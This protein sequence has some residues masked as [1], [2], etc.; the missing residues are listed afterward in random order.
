MPLMKEILLGRTVKEVR[1][2]LLEKYKFENDETKEKLEDII[3]AL[4][5]ANKP[6]VVFYATENDYNSV[7]PIN[8]DYWDIALDYWD[9]TDGFWL[10][11]EAWEDCDTLNK[12]VEDL[13]GKRKPY[14]VTKDHEFLLKKKGFAC[15]CCGGQ[16]THLS[17][18]LHWQP[19]PGQKNSDRGEVTHEIGCKECGYTWEN[20]YKV[21]LSRVD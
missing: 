2:Q 11:D 14:K 19:I 16:G 10:E 15:P 21:T 6:N 1:E 18:N 9:H 7:G 5:K 13:F 3:K 8:L 20:L 12:I 17:D 4:I